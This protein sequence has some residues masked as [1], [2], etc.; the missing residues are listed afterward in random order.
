LRICGEFYFFNLAFSLQNKIYSN[1]IDFGS[2]SEGVYYIVGV[3][4][5]KIKTQKLLI[6]H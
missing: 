4:G 6:K 2:I 3:N 5:T 1:E